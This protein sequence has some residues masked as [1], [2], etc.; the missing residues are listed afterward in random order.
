MDK[1]YRILDVCQQLDD[2]SMNILTEIAEV[3]TASGFSADKLIEES[4]D[5]DAIIIYMQGNIDKQVFDSATNLKVVGRL[6][7]GYNNIDLDEAIK[8]GIPVAWS[9]PTNSDTVADLTFGLLMAVARNISWGDRAF[10]NTRDTSWDYSTGMDF[11]GVDIW[12]KTIG[13]IG[14]GKM[15]RRIWSYKDCWF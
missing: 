4:K 5:V 1:K 14:Y 7:T 10:K 2:E 15:G 11:V 12:K 3:R 6:G 13:I 8:R 9:G